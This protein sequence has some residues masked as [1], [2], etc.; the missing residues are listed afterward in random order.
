MCN[1]CSVVLNTNLTP[2]LGLS[3]YF[4]LHKLRTWYECKPWENHMNSQGLSAC[5][6]LIFCIER[7]PDIVPWYSPSG[8]QHSLIWQ[9][10]CFKRKKYKNILKMFDCNLF[11]SCLWSLMFLITLLGGEG[12]WCYVH[13]E[14]QLWKHTIY[15]EYLGPCS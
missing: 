3:L 4:L 8:V 9:R 7:A 14:S 1:S 12:I 2:Y 5:T 13:L 6:K 10:L 15:L 11:C